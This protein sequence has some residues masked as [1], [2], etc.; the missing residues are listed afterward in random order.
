MPRYARSARRPF[1][2]LRQFFGAEA[3]AADCVLQRESTEGPFYLDVN[4]LRRD[5]H[6]KV[7]VGGDAVHTGQLYFRP[8]VT[9]AVYAQG[10]YR[11]RGRQDTS[12]ATDGIYGAEG[13]SRALLV[14]RR[15]GSTVGGGFSGGL[16]LGVRP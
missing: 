9:Q 6:V 13:G 5:I 16:T 10:R 2:T 11:G 15:R 4:L 3:A 14:L 7:F 8:A 1:P 12:T